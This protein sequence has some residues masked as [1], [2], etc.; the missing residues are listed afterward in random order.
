MKF[1]KVI[2]VNRLKNKNIKLQKGNQWLSI[3]SEL[4]H[5]IISKEDDINKIFKLSYCCDEAFIQTIV[6]N[7][8]FKDNLF[9]PNS[10]GDHTACARLIDWDRGNP[11]VLRK[12]DYDLIMSSPCMFARKFDLTVDSEII[13][14]LNESI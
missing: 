4:A 11:Y 14:M 1:E 6:E 5:Y 12:E 7:L 8:K 10:E 3:T 13:K 9:I 2:G